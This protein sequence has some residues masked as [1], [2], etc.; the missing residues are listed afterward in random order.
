M[1]IKKNQ[2]R[3]Q[4]ILENHYFAPGKLASMPKLK[5]FWK[6]VQ[7]CVVGKNVNN[8]LLLN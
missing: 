4:I 6:C 1:K 5:I 3:R 8:Y 2:V 7:P